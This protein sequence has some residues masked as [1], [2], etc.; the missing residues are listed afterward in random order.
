MSFHLFLIG[1]VPSLFAQILGNVR[2]I[3]FQ[4]TVKSMNNPSRLPRVLLT[5][6]MVSKCRYQQLVAEASVKVKRDNIYD[7]LMCKRRAASFLGSCCFQFQ[8]L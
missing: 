7:D 6:R 2:D 1:F 3:K 4:F 8:M 5:S